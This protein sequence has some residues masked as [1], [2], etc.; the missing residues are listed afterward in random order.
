MAY[1]KDLKEV[2]Y[3]DSFGSYNKSHAIQ[4][5]NKIGMHLKGE[6]D[7]QMNSILIIV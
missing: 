6:L 2:F 1:S 5:Q 7:K 4:V 3:L